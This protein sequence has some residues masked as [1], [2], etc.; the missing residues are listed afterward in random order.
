MR[1]WILIVGVLFVSHA[2]FA[3]G[4]AQSQKAD[5]KLVGK[6]YQTL[7]TLAASDKIE[8]VGDVH[9]HEKLKDILQEANAL[10][11]DGLQSLLGGEFE[12]RERGVKDLRMACQLNSLK[13]SANCELTI[14]YRPIGETSI[15]FDALLEEN[16]NKIS[17]LGNQ[18][19]VLRGD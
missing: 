16:G 14:Q 10:I 8:M 13:T 1:K 11:I 5:E 19:E 15:L 9:R 4:V 7:V 6:I 3:H 18:V 2:S 12:E 17:I